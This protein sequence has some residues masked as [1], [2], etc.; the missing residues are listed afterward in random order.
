[1]TTTSC[2]LAVTFRASSKVTPAWLAASLLHTCFYSRSR[3]QEI[4]KCSTNVP[5]MR[6]CNRMNANLLSCK[7][8]PCS[9]NEV[10]T[11]HPAMLRWHCQHHPNQTWSKLPPKRCHLASVASTLVNQRQAMASNQET[12]RNKAPKK[13]SFGILCNFKVNWCDLMWTV[14][15][16][17]P[18]TVTS[19]WQQLPWGPLV[20]W[21]GMA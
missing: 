7:P 16:R 14:S 18:K 17:H 21:N 8:R 2:T 11:H 1:M 15:Q 3:C 5:Q 4:H 19:S 6:M 20:H 12:T 10:D 13:V 9:P